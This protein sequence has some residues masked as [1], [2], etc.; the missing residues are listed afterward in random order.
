MFQ[1]FIKAR[2]P[3][4]EIGQVFRREDPI[5]RGSGMLTYAWHPQ[6]LIHT[7]L[8]TQITPSALPRRKAFGG[9]FGRHQDASQ[10]TKRSKVVRQPQKPGRD[11]SEAWSLLSLRGPG[12]SLPWGSKRNCEE[13]DAT[14]WRGGRLKAHL[15]RGA[16]APHL[17]VGH[18]N[19][20]ISSK[21]HKAILVSLP[22]VNRWGSVVYVCL[23]VT[24]SPCP[25]PETNSSGSLPF[26]CKCPA[27]GNAV[28]PVSSH[29]NRLARAGPQDWS[30]HCMSAPMREHGTSIHTSSK[31]SYSWDSNKRGGIPKQNTKHRE[32]KVNNI[33]TLRK[34]L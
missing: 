21:W 15:Q 3:L 7:Y 34:K 1:P 28:V 23:L 30:A 24:V 22:Y 16:R 14:L 26:R 4:P 33:G 11:K 6:A 12:P 18:E 17:L 31:T 19:T 32:S 5:W 20:L 27:G 9:R 10:R 13:L 25:R 2:D 29:H 8:T